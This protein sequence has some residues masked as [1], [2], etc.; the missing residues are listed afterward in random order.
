MVII[1]QGAIFLDNSYCGTDHCN[2]Y[3]VNL[4]LNILGPQTKKIKIYNLLVCAIYVFLRNYKSLVHHNS[5]KIMWVFTF[6][7][8]YLRTILD[9]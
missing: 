6:K 4:I 3:P 7:T 2:I 5:S 9:V 1:L 8:F